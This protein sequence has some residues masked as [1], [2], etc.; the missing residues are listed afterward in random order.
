LVF[1]LASLFI[2]IKSFFFPGFPDFLQNYY[3]PL[4]LMS[5]GNPYTFSNLPFFPNVYPPVTILF[6]FLFSFFPLIL[7]EKIWYIVSF[8]SLISSV[9]LIF[10]IADKN[11]FSRLGLMIFAFCFSSFPVKFTLGMGQINNLILLLIVSSVYLFKKKKIFSSAL[12]MTFSLSM[13]FFPILFPLYLLLIRKWKYLF[14]MLAVFVGLHFII[15]LMFP[16]LIIYF[17]TKIIFEFISGWKIDYY[18]QSLTGFIG[19]NISDIILREAIRI[20]LT[21]FFAIASLLIILNTISK[22]KLIYL[23][24]SFLITLNLIINNFSWQHHFVFMIIPFLFNLFFILDNKRYKELFVLA[25]SYALVSFNF[26]SPKDFSPLITS[27]V[28]YG[29][30]LMWGLQIFVILRSFQKP[31]PNFAKG[32]QH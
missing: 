17:Y 5:G 21:L 18:N 28:F 11:M 8:L 22:E 14:S 32:R 15:Y 13:K 23:H 3:S 9:Y 29:A 25:I 24:V 1:F 4:V 12:F 7:A 10:K 6:F 31:L 30:V 16:D 20:I 27:N 19:R 2:V 26:I